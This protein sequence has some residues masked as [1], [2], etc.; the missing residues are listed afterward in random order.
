M[1]YETLLITVS[2]KLTLAISAFRSSA[3]GGDQRECDTVQLK[4]ALE[5]VCRF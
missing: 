4:E 2:V 5:D 3:T 1:C